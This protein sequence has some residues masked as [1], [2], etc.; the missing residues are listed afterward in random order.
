MQ[1]MNNHADE[2]AEM[3]A[4]LPAPDELADTTA[5]SEY[6]RLLGPFYSSAGVMRVLGIPTERALAA[7]HKRGTL[8]ALPTSDGV[9]VYP[10]F[11]FD[12]QAHSVRRSLVP[13]L[14][15]LKNAPR[16]GAA[17]WLVTEHDDLEHR[18]P[19]IAAAAGPKDCKLVCRLAEQYSQAAVA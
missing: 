12:Q 3:S 18:S 6:D 10:A 2:L 19:L 1:Y 11:Q 7:R 13:V 5:R 17:L 15:Q 8:L 9:L 14:A 4:F 16:W